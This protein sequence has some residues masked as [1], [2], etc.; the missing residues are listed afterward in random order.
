MLFQYCR[1]A[2]ALP[3]QQLGQNNLQGMGCPKPHSSI[4]LHHDPNTEHCR[5]KAL[6][7][8][9]TRQLLTRRTNLLDLRQVVP[10][11]LCGQWCDL[12]LPALA[13]QGRE[14]H[15]TRSQVSLRLSSSAGVFA[16][17]KGLQMVLLIE[18]QINS[19]SDTVSNFF[20]LSGD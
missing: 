11:H 10:V 12:A 7:G 20:K 2:R 17:I 19:L 14:I 3:C 4:N 15:L 9:T 5:K 18:L 6:P 13:C 8:H 1:R 16:H